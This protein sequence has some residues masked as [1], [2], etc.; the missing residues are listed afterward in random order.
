MPTSRMLPRVLWRPALL[1]FAVS[2]FVLAFAP[3]MEGRFGPDS[4]AHAEQDG[5]NVHH[6]HNHAD[7][8]ACT[9]RDLMGTGEPGPRSTLPG[10]SAGPGAIA[11][12]KRTAESSQTLQTQSRSPPAI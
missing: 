11:S 10:S 3:L 5:T 1:F 12:A 4:R 8:A 9:A 7:C 2:Q 6:A